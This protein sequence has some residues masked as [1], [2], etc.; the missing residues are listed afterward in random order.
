[1]IRT[2]VEVRLRNSVERFFGYLIQKARRFHKKH[3][4]L[5]DHVNKRLRS[6]NNDDQ[7]HNH[8]NKNAKRSIT[9]LTGLILI[10]LYVLWDP[11]TVVHGVMH[12]LLDLLAA[13]V[14][15]QG[16]LCMHIYDSLDKLYQ[17]PVTMQK[18]SFFSTI[19]HCPHSIKI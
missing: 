1:L 13:I 6:I 12:V 3:K 19:L 17:K 4:H 15:H 10:L 18:R 9:W 14:K 11:A 8:I 2:I 5:K 7:K 16:R